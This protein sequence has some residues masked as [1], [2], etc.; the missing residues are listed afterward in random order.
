M[1]LPPLSYAQRFEDFHLWRCFDGQPQGF[2]IDIGGGHPVYDNVSLAFYLA[3]WRGIVAE[4]N[5][6]LAALSRAVRQRDHLHEGLCGAQAGEATLYLQREF[7]GLSTTIVEHAET[8]AREIGRAAEAVTLPMTTLAAL[9][10]QHAPASFEFLKVDVEGAEADVLR[11]ADFTRFRPK[12]IMVEAI[13]PISLKPAWDEWEPLLGKHG[14]AYVWDD[15]LNRYY[16]AKEARALAARLTEGPKWY[17][18]G[19][20]IGHYKPAAE[21]TTH[22]DHR[23]ALLLAG[24]DI[25]K[26]D[27]GKLDLGKLDLGKLPLTD[28]AVLFGMLTAGETD[29]ERRASDGDHAAIADRMFGISPAAQQI[30][31]PRL[32]A[33]E[34]VGETYRRLIDSDAFRTACGRIAASYAW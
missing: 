23:L 9:C 17:A 11:G 6:A 7:H 13:K 29:L 24:A 32:M 16:V 30:A 33:G 22:P 14:Y 8:A 20:Q 12:V 31:V 28:R 3:G 5:P 26:L 1:S 25:G 27:I 2:Y 18:D 10:E 19:P 21:D 15:E 34:S 4:P